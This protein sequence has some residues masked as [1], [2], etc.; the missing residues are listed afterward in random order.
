MEGT[1]RKI[2]VAS[3]CQTGWRGDFLGPTGAEAVFTDL[4][5]CSK[6]SVNKALAIAWIG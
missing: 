1:G 3:I 4:L 5:L 2:E 6:L